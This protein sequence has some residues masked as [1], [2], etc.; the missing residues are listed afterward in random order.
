MLR[1]HRKHDDK[2]QFTYNGQV[3]L[4]VASVEKDRHR[5]AITWYKNSWK[6][7]NYPASNVLSRCLLEFIYTRVYILERMLPIYFA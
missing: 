2:R 6:I 7:E 3:F 1:I 5:E 4:L